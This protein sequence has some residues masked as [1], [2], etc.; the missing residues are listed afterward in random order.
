MSALTRET[1]RADVAAATG[2]D[3]PHTTRPLPWLIAAFVVL[4]FTVPFQGIRFK[5][6]LPADATPDRLLLVAMMVAMVFSIEVRERG[7]KRR[8]GGVEC[9]VLIF[10]AVALI[11][12]AVNA[13]RLYRLDYLTFVD[14]QVLQMLS[15]VAFFFIAV[16]GVRLTEIH[17]FSR[18]VL[19]LS[20]ITS[21]AVILES[22]TG[23]NVFY[24]WWG[25]LL[26][27]IATVLASP[28]NLHPSDGSKPFIV[29]P[30]EH[31]L[32]LA[33]LLSVALPFAI[34]PL[35][36]ATR[37]RDRVGYVAAIALIIAAT[38]STREKT[39][40]FAPLTVIIVLAV[41][42]PRLI[43]WAPAGLLVMIPLIHI[44]A[45]GVL[46]EVKN[47]IP[48]ASG[49]NYSDGRTSDYAAIEPD[50]LSNLLIGRGFGSL[51]PLNWR[52]YRILDNEYLDELWTTGV[53]G[54]SSYIALVCTPV[55]AARRFA[56]RHADGNAYA[57]IAVIAA[58]GCGAFA[59]VSA[60]YDA[61]GF[62]EAIYSFLLMAALVA[63]IVREH[64]V[65]TP[66]PHP[67]TR[68]PVRG[69]GPSSVTRTPSRE[70]AR[71]FSTAT[72]V[73]SSQA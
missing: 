23:Y 6:H 11:S 64:A 21:L 3:W 26:K 69:S 18:L 12:V 48:G 41:L 5:L 52:W 1:P 67:P 59:T 16:R 19:R 60:T 65:R 20:C 68:R 66:A 53:I 22:R 24:I 45:P 54:L 43:R 15:Y 70:R 4:L 27:P 38:L 44:A 56:R 31:P 63:I 58:A 40:M 8:L 9:A 29:G 36:N 37:T 13:G 17:A 14:K 71:H 10:T 50:I 33:S 30:T 25:K 49:G 61:M 46:G 2:G 39:A 47:I 73:G 62:G 32:A 57:D 51:D 72:P 35:L 42:R 34:V 55:V 28:T 7:S